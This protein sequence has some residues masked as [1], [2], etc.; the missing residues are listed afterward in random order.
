MSQ[1]I[2]SPPAPENVETVE[3]FLIRE[4]LPVIRQ[5]PESE[6]Q[7]GLLRESVVTLVRVKDPSQKPPRAPSRTI[8]R[9]SWLSWESH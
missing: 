7:K 6:V 5:F 9:T 8:Y 1:P 3:E 4:Y 2:L